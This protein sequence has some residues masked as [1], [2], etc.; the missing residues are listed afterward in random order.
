MQGGRR[1]TATA[2][3]AA[4]SALKPAPPTAPNA[5]K[6]PTA[7]PMRR[8][9][10]FRAML[11]LAPGKDALLSTTNGGSSSSSACG[12]S[13]LLQPGHRLIVEGLDASCQQ[14]L[15]RE[16]TNDERDAS[17]QHQLATGPFA[18]GTTQ[19]MYGVEG[20][21]GKAAGKA[22][23]V[24][25]D[26]KTGDTQ[27]VAG[28]P[29]RPSL[30]G[31]E[32]VRATH[33]VAVRLSQVVQCFVAAKQQELIG[34]S[35]ILQGSVVPAHRTHCRLLC[36]HIEAE[37]LPAAMAALRASSAAWHTR[38]LRLQGLGGSASGQ[39]LWVGLEPAG[40]L[41][42]LRHAVVAEFSARG[43]DVLDADTVREDDAGM[44]AQRAGAETAAWSPH[45]A[46]LV[47]RRA[48]A[49]PGRRGGPV[50]LVRKRLLSLLDGLVAHSNV[51][52]G[53]FK[54][55]E[56]E[57]VDLGGPSSPSSAAEECDYYHVEAAA[58]FPSTPRAAR[59]W[60]AKPRP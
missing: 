8:V 30:A 4:A 6:S 57:L 46:L 34:G 9:M 15:L 41:R 16:M 10:R 23:S 12:L 27:A 47:A 55:R 54:A 32:E 13:A 33:V 40:E 25:T 59:P 43:F 37:R 58:P 3:A 21:A 50:A 42:A 22:V 52:L 20:K 39:V 18:I 35:S 26:A 1:Q 14:V 45:A 2:S 29:Q 49:A 38:R 11:A 53:C 60:V 51:D 56:L 31:L 24:P 28:P 19:K 44:L 48:K 36:T 5:V 7:V 17:S